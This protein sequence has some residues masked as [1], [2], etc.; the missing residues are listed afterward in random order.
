MVGYATY[1]HGDPVFEKYTPG[2][3]VAAGDV[4]I[5][6][7]TPRVAH[8]DIPAGELGALAG[9]GGI[10]EMYADVAIA[11]DKKVYWDPAN[12]WV[13]ATAGALKPFGYTT[14]ATTGAGQTLYV[15][16]DPAA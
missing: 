13:T 10:Y 1:R 8:L 9:A 14:T 4:V 3:N 15:R 12:H 6:N 5:V 16:H 7:D 2:A 11:A